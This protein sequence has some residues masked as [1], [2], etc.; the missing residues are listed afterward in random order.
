MNSK[1]DKFAVRFYALVDWSSSY[2]FSVVDNGR[3]SDIPT[4]QGQKYVSLH[5]GMRTPFQKW[6]PE[7]KTDLPTEVESDSATALWVTMLSHMEQAQSSGREKRVVY[8]DNFYTRAVLADALLKMSDGKIRVTGTVRLN[9]VKTTDLIH[10]TE[11]HNR[12]KDMSRGS[13]MLVSSFVCA[14]DLSKQKTAHTKK[15]AKTPKADVPKFVPRLGAQRPHAGY[16]V[17]KDKG[18]VTMFSND[19]SGDPSKILLLGIDAKQ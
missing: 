5:R 7:R 11:A 14:K 13:W 8:M 2:L 15:Y 1:P 12:L 19:L 17:V 10:L 3:G 4:S 9:F 18:I 16:I 6:F